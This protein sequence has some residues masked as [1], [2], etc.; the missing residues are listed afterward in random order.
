MPL[1]FQT[2]ST[3]A[4]NFGAKS[5]TGVPKKP[6]SSDIKFFSENS[7]GR[8]LY[9]DNSGYTG[10][11]AR[12]QTKMIDAALP[13]FGD[14]KWSVKVMP[15]VNADTEGIKYGQ[16]RVT[17]ALPTVSFGSAGKIN[18]S[19]RLEN[20]TTL[21]IDDKFRKTD[22]AQEPRAVF[23]A[24]RG[25]W[26]A[27]AVLRAKHSQKE[28][29]LKVKD[30]VFTLLKKFDKFSIYGD[31]YMPTEAFTKGDFDKTNYALGMTYNF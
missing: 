11:S 29:G 31:V 15:M 5:N 1:T 27:N 14:N 23:T 25:N 13:S 17:T 18:F 20:R 8:E 26:E 12:F 21:K 30:A 9:S 6:K 7:I 19:G 28:S 10:Y 16:L 22:F 24:K 3:S 4:Q 2:D